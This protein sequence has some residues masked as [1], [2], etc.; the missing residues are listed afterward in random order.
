MT[1]STPEKAG[2][3]PSWLTPNVLALGLVSLL[4]DAASEMI[5]P[6]FPLFLTVTLGGAPAMLGLVE[7]VADA[8][9]SVLKLVSGRISD[10]YGHRV[11]MVFGGY[12]LAT[13]TRPAIALAT[14]PWAVLVFRVIDRVG[15]GLRTSPRDALLAASAPAGNLGAVFGFHR[16][17]DHA[18]AVVGALAAAILLSIGIEDLRTIFLWSVVPS[19]VGLVVIALVIRDPSPGP[20]V[21]ASPP[22]VAADA[23]PPRRGLLPGALPSGPLRGYLAAIGIFGLGHATDAFL[24][25][26]A[27]TAGVRTHE[28]P[29]LWMALHVVKSVASLWAGPLADRVGRRRVIVAGWMVAAAIYL[30]FAAADETAEFTALFIVYG[31]Y[32]GLTEGAERAVAVELAGGATGTALGWYNLVTGLVALPAGLVF[33]AIWTFAGPAAAFGYGA[34]LAVVAMGVLTWTA[35][36]RTT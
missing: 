33:G 20:A 11:P 23:P 27:G 34:A 21:P 8:A 28:L 14:G 16:A 26:Q 22:P 17:M 1:P 36:P 30:L 7:G 24:L 32:H 5:Q 35:R 15:K 9:S 12:A 19:L 3:R 13:L 25:L 31:L 29:I 6:L 2:G 10:R 4:N 18:G